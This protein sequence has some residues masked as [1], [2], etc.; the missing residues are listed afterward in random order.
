MSFADPKLE[1]A[2]V[3]SGTGEPPCKT[4]EHPSGPVPTGW[5]TGD[6]AILSA[7]N[8]MN[9][10]PFSQMVTRLG[11]AGMVVLASLLMQQFG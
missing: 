11:G 6:V 8:R 7:A 5:N 3:Q 2:P 9:L 4:P 1:S 10:M